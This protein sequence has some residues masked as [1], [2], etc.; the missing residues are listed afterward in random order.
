MKA[1]VF[2]GPTISA[3]EAR[4]ELDAVYLPPAAQGDVYLAALEE[5]AAIGIIDGYFERIQSVSHK[6]VLWAMS[7]GIHVFGAA[8]MG[9]LRAA[10]LAA[11]G[12]EGAGAVYEAFAR[13]ELEDDDEVAV[14]H[15]P[16]EDGYRCVSEA[17]VN[18]RATLQAAQRRGV[19]GG[20]AREGLERLAK[21]RFY[22]ERG[23]R[24]LL[25]DAAREGL[26]P[27]ELEAL[28]TFLPEGR[29]DQK[30]QDALALLRLMRAR[31]AS[32]LEPKRVRYHFPHTDAWEF[33]RRNARERRVESST[34]SGEP[35]TTGSDLGGRR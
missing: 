27:A 25:V 34:R 31:L 1:F 10:E 35:S 23:Y 14:A 28:E 8:S 18:I 12:M 17:M 26:A 11:F 24:Q 9:A 7:Q 15:A 32:G 6:E 16:G 22:R 33:I 4:A 19:L 29:V 20:A 2:V 21:A 13:G 30:R 3:E 5:P